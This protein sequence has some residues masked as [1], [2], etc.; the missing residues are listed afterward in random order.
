MKHR[1]KCAYF[2]LFQDLQTSET[3][4]TETLAKNCPIL[5]EICGTRNTV[6]FKRD[7]NSRFEAVFDSDAEETNS[8]IDPE[9]DYHMRY[10]L[11]VDPDLDDYDND[12]Y[13]DNAFDEYDDND[14]Y[15]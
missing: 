4:I 15:S 13:D 14:D 3:A 6:R 1:N 5:D 11:G 8:S 12:I 9:E 7:P 10:V 2:R